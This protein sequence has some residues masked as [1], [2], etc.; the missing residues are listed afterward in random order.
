MKTPDL[1]PCPMCWCKFPDMVT[2]LTRW[3]NK[4]ALECPRCH[5]FSKVAFT[6]RGAIRKWNRIKVE[7]EER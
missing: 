6:K 3:F 1:K 5:F 7:G 2:F 4:Y